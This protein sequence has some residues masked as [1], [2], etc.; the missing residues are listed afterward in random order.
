MKSSFKVKLYT[1]IDLRPG[2]VEAH[3]KIQIHET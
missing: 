2:L 1:L 3:T